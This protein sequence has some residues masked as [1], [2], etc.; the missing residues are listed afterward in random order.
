[1]DR[2]VSRRKIFGMRRTNLYMNSSIFLSKITLKILIYKGNHGCYLA[3]LH[4][5]ESFNLGLN[6][7]F[8]FSA[9]GIR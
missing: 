2:K 7:S 9:A 4:F 6:V 8:E 5:K 1:M 3:L